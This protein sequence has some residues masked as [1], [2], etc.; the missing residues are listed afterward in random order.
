ML[1][2]K[3]SP[4]ITKR[5]PILYADINLGKKGMHRIAVHKDDCAGKLADEFAK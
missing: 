4:E 5:K 2:I 1:R 3:N